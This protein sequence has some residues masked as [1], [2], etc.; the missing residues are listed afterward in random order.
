[1]NENECKVK[2]EKDCKIN[3]NNKQCKVKSCSKLFAIKLKQLIS[4]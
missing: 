3:R 4:K 1:M 2:N